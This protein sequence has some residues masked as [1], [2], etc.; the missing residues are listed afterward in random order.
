MSLKIEEP[1]RPLRTDYAKTREREITTDIYLAYIN[2][3]PDPRVDSKVIDAFDA[4]RGNFGITWH[5]LIRMDGTI[6]RGRDFHTVGAQPP[7]DGKGLYRETTISIGVVGGRNGETY[8]VEDTLTDAQAE[9]IEACLQYCADTAGVPLEVTDRVTDRAL[10]HEQA[11]EEY[12]RIREERLR[13]RHEELLEELLE[14]DEV[15]REDG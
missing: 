13:E 14:E 15:I 10:R 8:E 1:S 11:Q 6:E 12:Q 9:A 3:P 4:M 2:C 5:L 7:R